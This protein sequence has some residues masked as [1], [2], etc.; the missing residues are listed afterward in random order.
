MF[1]IGTVEGGK[2]MGF[3][4]NAIVTV[5]FCVVCGLMLSVI[6][7]DSDAAVGDRFE[8]GD[9]V[10]EVIRE[11]SVN[12]VEVYDTVNMMVTE[13]DGVE[14]VTNGGIS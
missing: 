7:G 3:L 8:V 6:S 10:Y 13:Y 12:E 5:L 11:G 2:L 4:R 9:I 14:T 1:G